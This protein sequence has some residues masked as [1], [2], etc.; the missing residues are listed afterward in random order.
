MCSMPSRMAIALVATMA[1][2]TTSC[3]D[4]ERACPDFPPPFLNLTVVDSSTGLHVCTA[5]VAVAEGSGP[6]RVEWDRANAGLSDADCSYNQFA[7]RA[8][9]SAI[10]VVTVT[11]QAIG[12]ALER[13]VTVAFDQCQNPN[14]WQSIVIEVAPAEVG[15]P[16][17]SPT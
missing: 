15:A 4:V 3:G 8:G 10:Y 2:A 5:T 17:S 7:T 1:A 9:G 14:T 13:Q 6:Q 12:P 11:G 16:V